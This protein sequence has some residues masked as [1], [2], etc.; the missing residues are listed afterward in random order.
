M[1]KNMQSGRSML[2]MLG[3]LAIVGVLSVGGLNLVNKMQLSRTV[4]SVIDEI[5]VLSRKVRPVARDYEGS[6]GLM[7]DKIYDAKAYP[8]HFVLDMS[9]YSGSGYFGGTDDISYNVYYYKTQYMLYILEL[10]KV[11][12]EVCMQL[13]TSNWGSV[14]SSGFVG[15]SVNADSYYL[16]DY[17]LSTKA[18]IPNNIGIAGNKDHPVPMG[19]GTA[20]DICTDGATLRFAFR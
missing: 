19:I 18:S 12:A 3:V 13:V 15:L 2:E 10:Q 5:T 1:N 6:L 7:N 20:A 16:I 4:N 14:S 8:D 9:T 11:S 17:I